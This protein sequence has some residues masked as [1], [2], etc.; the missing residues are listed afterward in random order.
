MTAVAMQVS[1]IIHQCKFLLYG[2]NVTRGG[3]SHWWN[4]SNIKLQ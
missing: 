2:L 1:K 3:T 4:E